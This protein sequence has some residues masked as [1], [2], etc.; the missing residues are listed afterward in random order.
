[1]IYV[2]GMAEPAL[3]AYWLWGMRNVGRCMRKHCE[4]SCSLLQNYLHAYGSNARYHAFQ[5]VSG[6][7]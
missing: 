6:R 5:A 3:A 7:R 4:T 2:I 1:M